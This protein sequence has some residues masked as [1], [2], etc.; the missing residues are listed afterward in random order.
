MIQQVDF[1]RN[2]TL[3]GTLTLPG[4]T[5]NEKVPAVVFI[6]GSGALDR[7]ENTRGL[8]LNVFN[9]LGDWFAG[10]GIASLRYDKRGT[11]KSDGV[12]AEAGMEDLIDDAAAAVAFAKAHPATDSD[13]IFIVGHSEGGMIAPSIAEKSEVK[14]LI[15]LA[16]SSRP[17]LDILLTQT[18][19]LEV[20]VQHGQGLQYKLLRTAGVH[21]NSKRKHQKF[22]QKTIQSENDTYRL[23]GISKINAKWFKEH[24]NFSPAMSLENLSIPILAVNGSRDVQVKGEDVSEIAAA[25]G[26][27]AEVHVIDNMN[28]ILRIQ[29]EEPSILTAKRLYRKYG[30]EAIASELYDII[31]PWILKHILSD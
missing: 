20:E 22:I 27:A 8:K 28:H 3:R 13:K 4:H 29:E 19:D 24:S 21:H 23:K 25:A 2:G 9:R 5:R 15:L 16:S 7:D 30:R 10:Q 26:G 11:G 14:G 31:Q 17:L 1:E 12:Y 6:H 18:E